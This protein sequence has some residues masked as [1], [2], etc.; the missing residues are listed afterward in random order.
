MKLRI[1]SVITVILSVAAG[2]PTLAQDA[3]DVLKTSPRSAERAEEVKIALIGDTEAGGG[4][5]S[6]LKLINAERANAVMINGDLGYGSSPSSWKQR[7]LASV[8]PDSLAVIGALGNHDMGKNAATYVSVF[9]GLR[10]EKNGLKAAC[11]GGTA[12]TQNRD[13]A[14]VDEVCTLGN[15]T[16]VASAIGQLFSKAYF[17]TRLEQKLKAAPSANW[18][19]A[20]YHFTLSSMNP[21]LKGTQSS[22]RFFEI[23]RQHGAI[24]AQAHTH[25]VM[26][27]CPISSPFRSA[28]AAT[29]CHPEFK[30]LEARFVAPGTGLYL[31]S[32]VGGKEARNR[33]RCKNPAESGCKHMIDL[34]TGDGYTRVDGT[35]L[36]KFN[37]LGALFI[38]FNHERDPKKALA[39][40][41]SV[42]GQTIFKFAILR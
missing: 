7:L 2:R 26:A 36:T 16:I 6:V 10:N 41:K 37:R 21:G 9:A 23:L 31:D 11:T 42:D 12:M 32:S 8:N 28:R 34:I 38:V 25:S 19:L 18:K 39:Y 33:G 13:I 40:F 1:F 4:F 22:A 14:A 15:V 5:A 35:K 30:A 24:G 29:A 17:E 3:Y 27:S 20:G